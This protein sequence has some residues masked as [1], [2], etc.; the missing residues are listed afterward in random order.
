MA[1]IAGGEADAATAQAITPF[2]ADY[3]A[4]YGIK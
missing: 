1:D 2:I 3:M 4:L